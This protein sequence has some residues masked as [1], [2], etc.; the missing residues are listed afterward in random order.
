[1]MQCPSKNLTVTQLVLKYSCGSI[2]FHWTSR[3]VGRV[4]QIP[5]SY[6]GGS[7]FKCRPGY[8]IVML[9]AVLLSPSKQTP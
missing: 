6:T 4:S 8:Y 2:L 1:M 7:G 9:L 5:S 3:R